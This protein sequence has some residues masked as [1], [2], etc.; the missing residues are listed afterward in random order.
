MSFHRTGVFARSGI[1]APTCA[2]SES[3]MIRPSTTHASAPSA[4]RS[5]W[6][7]R[8][9]HFDFAKRRVHT[10]GCSTTRST[11]L[12]IPNLDLISNQNFRSN[13]RSVWQ[14]GEHFLDTSWGPSYILSLDGRGLRLVCSSLVSPV[15]SKSLKTVQRLGILIQ[16]LLALILEHT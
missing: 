6:G 14:H 3:G 1:T 4:P 9:H 5:M 16:Q 15:I 13:P 2:I 7:M 12:M 10:S 11:A 8:S